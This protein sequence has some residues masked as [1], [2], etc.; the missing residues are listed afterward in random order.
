[1]RLSSASNS[2]MLEPP[3]LEVTVS[4][5]SSLSTCCPHV[6]FNSKS[7]PV[8][9]LPFLSQS[10]RAPQRIAKG[11]CLL[12]PRRYPLAHSQNGHTHPKER[13]TFQLVTLGPASV[14]HK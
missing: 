7:R 2:S 12:V 1:M 4:Q 13:P 14:E 5:D 6:K 11:I 3:P 10:S 8:P 9:S